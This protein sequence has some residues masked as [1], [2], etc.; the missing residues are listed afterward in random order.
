MTPT[1][2]LT[3]PLPWLLAIFIALAVLYAWATP[4]FEASDELWHFGMVERLATVGTLPV[5]DPDVTT[6]WEQEGSQPPLYYAITAALVRP[7]DLSGL[8]DLRQPNPHTKAGIPLDSDNKNLVL[9]DTPYPALTGSGV[10]KSVLPVYIARLFS[11]LLGAVTVGAVYMAGRELDPTHEWVGL[12]AAGLTAFNPMFLFI[13][14]SVNNDNLVI[15]LG[16]LITWQ[17]LVMLREGLHWRRS[18]L[19][20]ILLALASLTKISG[21][22]FVPVVAL[23]GFTIALQKR[24]WR[25]LIT[26][27]ALMIGSW[28]L[29]AGW[30]YWR[31]IQLYGELFGTTQMVAVAGPRLEP[32]TLR[33]LLAEFEGFRISYWGLFGGVNVLTTGWFYKVMDLLTIAAITGLVLV[34]WR[35]EADRTLLL[36]IGLL[37]LL[38]ALGIAGVVQ[39]TAQT[40]ASQGRLLFPF[41]AALSSLTALGL[42]GLIPQKTG[43]RLTLA[44]IAL[45]GVA[46]L[47]M[48]L[49]NIAPAYAQPPRLD[50]LPA[51]AQPVYAQFGE[52]VTL[53]GY[54]TEDKRREPGD[55]VPVTLYWA[56]DGPTAENMSLYVHAVN[57]AGEVLGKVDTYPGGGSLQTTTWQPGIY[58]DTYAIPLDQDAAGRS[59]LRL[60]IGW[61]HYPS[62][63]VIIPTNDNSEALESVMIGAG[64]FVNST[65][66]I[67][68]PRD[69]TPVAAGADFGGVIRLT[70][71][72]ADHD[73]DDDNEVLTLAWAATG[74]P[75]ANYTVFVQVLAEDDSIIGQGDAPPDLPTSYWRKG[76][77][78]TST[79]VITY[80]AAPAPGAYRV[81][82]GWYAPADFARLE[83]ARADNAYLL[84]TL[85]LP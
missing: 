65:T 61:W 22:V 21:N 7:F 4:I 8:D 64:G 52:A 60:S 42:V 69:L 63:T 51:D 77:Q 20:A 5:Q 57:S 18:L 50:A 13:T 62:E 40:Y 15:M 79:H 59:D 12:L 2:R 25:G 35:R 54:R 41:I 78:Y 58:A 75:P 37:A 30:W 14:A 80:P 19:L 74:T 23:A 29:I 3:H 85:D 24:D 43:H 34:I 33:T 32:F 10:N 56:V 38:A 66:P 17:T 71:Y 68:M 31:N 53:V 44:G 83:T 39:W 26:L 73:R 9:H 81:L 48:P 72:Q 16:A 67:E 47:L 36:R 82:I 11:I 84:T 76:E 6:P 55:Y 49:V 45:L 27:A 28:L 70:G 46:A 1:R